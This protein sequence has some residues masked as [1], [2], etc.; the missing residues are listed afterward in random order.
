MA[1]LFIFLLLPVSI[2]INGLLLSLFWDWF[3]VPLGVPSVGAAHALGISLI[4]TMLT[5][6]YSKD[7]R[8]ASEVL[9]TMIVRPL[10]LLAFA[11]LFYSFM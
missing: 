8:E 10:Y 4:V 9:L 3:F 6:N 2:I 1:V 7:E 11:A 5:Y